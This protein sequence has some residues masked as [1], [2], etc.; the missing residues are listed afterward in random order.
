MA[1]R[2]GARALIKIGKSE[3]TGPDTGT[4]LFPGKIIA[5]PKATTT[6]NRRPNW[7]VTR[8][9]CRKVHAASAIR[10][11]PGTIRG[12][13]VAAP[14]PPRLTSRFD[15][16]FARS[17]ASGHQARTAGRDASRWLLRGPRSDGRRR[18]EASRRLAPAAASG[19]DR[20]RQQ[21]AIAEPLDR[22]RPSGAV[23]HD[24][25][26]RSFGAEYPSHDLSLCT[27]ATCGPVP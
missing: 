24:P 7:A 22:S 1:A 13:A 17:P 15:Q 11:P 12:L 14:E 9:R 16:R 19:V 26:L 18:E 27:A 3:P 10:L 2:A 23:V 4:Q 6:S 21:I 5:A 8:G 25:R 20:L